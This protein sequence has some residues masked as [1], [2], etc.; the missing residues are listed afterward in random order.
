MRDSV[1]SRGFCRSKHRETIR[2]VTIGPFHLMRPLAGSFDE[3]FQEQGFVIG[4]VA[5]G[6]IELGGAS[7]KVKAALYSRGGVSCPTRQMFMTEMPA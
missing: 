4:K 5:H 2:A 3:G 7:A 1:K 6:V